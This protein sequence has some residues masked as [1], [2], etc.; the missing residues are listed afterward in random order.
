MLLNRCAE[1]TVV[2]G[3]SAFGEQVVGFRLG[4]GASWCLARWVTILDVVENLCDEF[5]LSDVGDDAK[6]ATA[7]SAQSD[8]DFKGCPAGAVYTD[9]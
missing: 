7:Q 4:R 2:A 5:R 9:T 3:V 8:V 1:S 6:L